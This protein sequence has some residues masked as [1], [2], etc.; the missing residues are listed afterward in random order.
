MVNNI[1]IV[2]DQCTGCGICFD[3]CSELAVL[4]PRETAYPELIVERCSGCLICAAECPFEA[5][6]VEE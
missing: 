6:V 2:V 4:M 5:I 3:V 1:C